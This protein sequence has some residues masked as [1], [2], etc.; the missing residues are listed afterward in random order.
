MQYIPRTILYN[1]WQKGAIFMPDFYSSNIISHQF[2]VDNNE[3]ETG[4]GYDMII[5]RNLMAQL[6][7]SYDFKHQVL[8]Q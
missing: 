5:G 8:Q 7:L 2:H 6:G 4:I 1:E 3:G